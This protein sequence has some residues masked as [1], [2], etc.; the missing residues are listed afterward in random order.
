MTTLEL[1]TLIPKSK[2]KAIS[3]AKLKSLTGIHERVIR[4]LIKQM[5]SQRIPILSSSGCSGYWISY[6]LNEIESFIKE[7]ERRANTIIKTL[8]P[9]IYIRTKRNKT[10]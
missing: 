5:V 9:N 8:N 4:I 1:L 3:R 6:D 2:D 7:G 10:S